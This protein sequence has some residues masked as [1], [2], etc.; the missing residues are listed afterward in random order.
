MPAFVLV[1]LAANQRGALV[2]VIR[3]QQPLARHERFELRQPLAL[4][5]V[6]EIACRVNEPP[7]EA[8]HA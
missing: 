2:I 7:V 5:V 6:V 3:T 4:E 8:L 1:S